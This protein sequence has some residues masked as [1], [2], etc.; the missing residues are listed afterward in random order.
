MSAEREAAWLIEAAT[1]RRAQELVSHAAD[2]DA[3]AVARVE[4]LVRRRAAGEP[5]QYLTGIAGFRQLELLVGPGVFIPRPETELVAGR[6]MELLPPRGRAV[7]VGTGSGAIALSVALERP[8]A[9]VYATESSSVALSYAARNRDATGLG[10]ELAHCDLLE[11]LP[12]ELRGA[13]DVCVSNPPYVPTGERGSLPRDVAD[14]EP[15]EA[16][17]SAGDGL[18]VLR[19]LA[20]E[21]RR[22]LRPGGW[23]VAE[24]GDRQGTPAR[25]LLAAAGYRDVVV[26]R[27][28]AGRERIVEGRA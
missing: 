26:S 7:D 5:L 23:L 3:G 14:H 15:A 18:G 22:W 1:G 17:F 21:A 28:L 4:A 19:R 9:T 25:A 11:G 20:S 6:A 16:L 8:D 13:V 27:D 10:V 12:Q 24:I 2:V